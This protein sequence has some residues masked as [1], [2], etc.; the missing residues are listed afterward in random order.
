MNHFVLSPGDNFSFCDCVFVNGGKKKVGFIIADPEE[1]PKGDFDLKSA[2][3]SASRHM[4]DQATIEELKAERIKL[5]QKLARRDFEL[6]KFRVENKVKQVE[7]EIS[8]VEEKEERGQVQQ[9][10][11]E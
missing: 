4:I 9:D 10:R 8:R 3:E 6:K 1:F 11:S 7:E 2:M 5:L